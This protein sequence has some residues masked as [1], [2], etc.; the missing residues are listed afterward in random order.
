MAEVRVEMPVRHIEGNL[1]FSTDG[2]VWAYYEISTYDY[3]Y[4]SEKEKKKMRARWYG[5]ARQLPYETH[6]LEIPE[7]PELETQ[8][9][10][11]QSGPLSE[12]AKKHR[13]LTMKV[14]TDHLK[15]PTDFR[16][17]IGFKL[18]RVRRMEIKQQ[19][20]R[21]IY[22]KWYDLRRYIGFISG[23]RPYDILEEELFDYQEA[24]ELIALELSSLLVHRPVTTRELQWYFRS[25]V[26]RGVGEPMLLEG[27]EPL[28][29][30][31]QLPH[32][33]KEETEKFQAI[34]PYPN[35]I[36]TLIPGAFETKENQIRVCVFDPKAGEEKTS[37]Q[38]FLYVT[39]MKDDLDF[40]GK[41]EWAYWTHR[42]KFPV[43]VSV[44]YHSLSNE[45]AMK[46]LTK[47]KLR[48][49][50]D[51]KYIRREG[52]QTDA[53]AEENYM[54][55]VDIE[56]DYRESED[57]P[58]IYLTICFCVSAP[59]ESLLKSRIRQVVSDYN[60]RGIRMEVS[61]GDQ[62]LGFND[63]L[64]GGKRYVQDYEIP[65]QPDVVAEAM[66]G[67]TQS[68]G[69]SRG[70]F[71]GFTGPPNI[72]RSKLTKP[73]L[74]HPGL[75]AQNVSD[76]TKSLAMAFLGSTGFGKS[77]AMNLVIYLAVLML[78]AMA[79]LV[80][81][82]GDRGHWPQELPWL[83][84]HTNVI[85][86]GA[87]PGEETGAM[88]PFAV[89]QDNKGPMYAKDFLTQLLA[90]KRDHPWYLE[91]QDAVQEVRDHKEPCMMR[92]L[93]LLQKKDRA[94]YNALRSYVSYPFAHLV[95]GEG[96]RSE[97]ALSFDHRINILQ[98][99]GLQVPDQQKKPAD[100][101]ELEALSKALM[102]PITA[103]TDMFSLMDRSILKIIGW[104]EAWAP[105]S[106]DI[107][108]STLNSGMREGRSR[109]TSFAL[110]SQNA[111][112]IKGE[113]MN[114][115]GNKF[116]FNMDDPVQ[117]DRSLEILKLEKNETN[118]ENMTLLGEGEC[119][120][121]DIYGRVG[122]LQFDPLF[123]ELMDVFSTTPPS[124]EEINEVVG[125]HVEV[126]G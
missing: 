97:K 28:K 60:R 106:S 49:K 88:D 9:T 57:K 85:T 2:S 11:P 64:P 51:V 121:R 61:A 109:N 23:L 102:T 20:R 113:L 55:A 124:E 82:K 53:Y 96:K 86:L 6:I 30:N 39:Y 72:Q 56:A 68:L 62:F 103:Y 47:R 104:D 32:P 58:L 7:F 12:A 114:N 25:T 91:I 66:F 123:Q 26:L 87:N 38:A 99:Q 1:V 22:H 84:E 77:L 90:I 79:V 92:V 73:V 31:I 100:Y 19:M 116:I 15:E 16:V 29:E 33:A 125:E 94:L 10:T 67:A 83:N 93:D 8:L 81:P 71:I 18:P 54:K 63:F 74:F 21:T 78:R 42:F 14:L 17:F 5:I 75:A 110:C 69:D 119:F 111:T 120:F 118:R 43:S 50:N 112:D 40:P 80:D 36:R 45:K 108:Q 117:I 27:W 34:R 107:G 122:R 52:Q 105:L 65:V 48:L 4:R 59:S 115:V 44:R 35:V 70:F 89:F 76:R 101:S 95:F 37:Y 13:D 41:A 46:E 98:I 24:E 3:A 126:V